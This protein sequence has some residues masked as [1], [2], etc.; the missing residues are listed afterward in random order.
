MVMLR[1]LNEAQAAPPDEDSAGEVEDVRFRTLDF[2]ALTATLHEVGGLVKNALQTLTPAE[3]EVELGL[4][5]SAKTGQLLVL[6]GEAATQASLKVTLKWRF[7]QR[8][9]DADEA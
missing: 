9:D 4:G 5:F 3:A 6:F 7:D 2:R 1:G 8:S